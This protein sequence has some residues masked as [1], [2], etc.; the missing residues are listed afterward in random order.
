MR[1]Q[2]YWRY[3]PLYRGG[4]LRSL[5]LIE[6]AEGRP[7]YLF[8]RF[9]A[10]NSSYA[11]CVSQDRDQVLSQAEYVK[12]TL[13]SDFLSSDTDDPIDIDIPQFLQAFFEGGAPN[14]K[15]LTL[16]ADVVNWVIIPEE[17]FG[18]NFPCLRSLTLEHVECSWLTPIFVSSLTHLILLGPLYFDETCTQTL[19]RLPSLRY[20]DLATLLYQ[21]H[22]GTSA[23][24][25]PF[26]IPNDPPSVKLEHLEVLRVRGEGS[27]LGDLA[28]ELTIPLSA[29]IT[30]VS[31]CPEDPMGNSLHQCLD[32]K[33]LIYWLSRRLEELDQGST[34]IH[35]MHIEF[36]FNPDGDD[37]N[38]VLRLHHSPDSIIDPVQLPKAE[39]PRSHL[40]IEFCLHQ[41]ETLLMAIPKLQLST[42][43]VLYLDDVHPFDVETAL[44]GLIGVQTLCLRG[45]DLTHMLQNLAPTRSRREAL[46]PALRTLV[47]READFEEE[48]S[49]VLSFL[50]K[51]CPPVEKVY[52]SQCE[53]VEEEYLQAM[54]QHV[55]TVEWDEFDL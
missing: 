31:L 32:L 33:P 5:H 1:S 2:K 29:S 35:T 50:A 40:K 3:Q 19:Q 45:Q 28:L 42:V 51:R 15:S 14:L 22:P 23:P 39:Y 49:H 25:P 10:D 34:P 54:L 20:L 41:R 24:I 48:F 46:L 37:Q 12:V 53:Y 6:R 27:L 44:G 9:P 4:Q 36:G 30:L 18:S 38:G 55:S 11:C 47:L 52:L 43:Q 8:G 7:L 26:E 16:S 21:D 13:D 17:A